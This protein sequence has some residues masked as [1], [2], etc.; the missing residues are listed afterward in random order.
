MKALHF[1]K[2]HY[3]TKFFNQLLELIDVVDFSG[4]EREI[5]PNVSIPVQQ[6]PSLK[7]K[8]KK[9]SLIGFADYILNNIDNAWDF[10]V[11]KT[12]QTINFGI[13]RPVKWSKNQVRT[14][15]T[16]VYKQANKKV[17]INVMPSLTRGKDRIQ[18]I[19]V[20]LYHKALYATQIALSPIKWGSL[21]VYDAW[22]SLNQKVSS[23]IS[24]SRKILKL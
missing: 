17:E 18:K 8:E 6:V 13:V 21:Q 16:K 5:F 1:E 7:E 4:K 12:A 2:K 10:S 20:S 11:N 24:G 15:T 23:A 19:S 14:V 3:Q 9:L 22:S